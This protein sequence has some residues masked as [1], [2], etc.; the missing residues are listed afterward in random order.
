MPSLW[1]G[2]IENQKIYQVSG[3]DAKGNADKDA[4]EENLQT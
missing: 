1:L 3:I 4:N 2:I